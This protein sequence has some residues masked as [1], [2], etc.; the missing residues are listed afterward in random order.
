TVPGLVGGPGP[1]PG[2]RRVT[3]IAWRL[4]HLHPCFAGQW[5]WTFG[6]RRRDPWLLVD[7]TSPASGN[8]GTAVIGENDHGQGASALTLFSYSRR[9]LRWAGTAGRP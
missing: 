6:E 5:E 2:A 7:F 8:I 4:A 3:T 9:A 1:A